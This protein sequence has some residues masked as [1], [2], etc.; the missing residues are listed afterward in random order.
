MTKKLQP[1]VP[2]LPSEAPERSSGVTSPDKSLDTGSN[3][4][5]TPL[6]DSYDADYEYLPSDDEQH[7][8]TKIYELLLSDVISELSMENNYE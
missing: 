7:R 2:H 8:L 1:T 6:L 5:Y 4:A 3:P